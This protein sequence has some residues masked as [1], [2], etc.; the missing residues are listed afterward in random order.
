MNYKC[1]VGYTRRNNRYNSRYTVVEVL[2]NCRRVIEFESG[3]KTTASVTNVCNGSVRDKFHAVYYGVGYI[4]D[5]QYKQN[6]HKKIFDF[7]VRMLERSNCAKFKIKQQHYRSTTCCEEW[8]DFQNFAQWVESQAFYAIKG[9]QLDKDL[10]GQGR[11]IYSPSTC[12]FLPNN[13]NSSL[14]RRKGFVDHALP[15]GVEIKSGKYVT[16][17]VVDG[18]RRYLGAFDSVNDAY[19][20]YASAKEGEVRRLAGEYREVLNVDAYNALMNYK[21]S[22]SGTIE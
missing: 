10:L 12:C 3:Y 18:R 2:P 4:G 19:L 5:G 6:T 22:W 21:A 13:I 14:M 1:D 7:W 11:D 20:A 15:R 16:R 9:M 17:C 8:Y